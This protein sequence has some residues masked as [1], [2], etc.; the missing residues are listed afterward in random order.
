MQAHWIRHAGG[1][2]GAGGE[3]VV[4]AFNRPPAGLQIKCS[5]PRWHQNIAGREKRYAKASLEGFLRIEKKDV[6][7]FTT[8]DLT[9]FVVCLCSLSQGKTIHFADRLCGGTEH[10]ALNMKYWTPRGKLIRRAVIVTVRSCHRKW[11]QSGPRTCLELRKFRNDITGVRSVVNRQSSDGA[12]SFEI[13]RTSTSVARRITSDLW[14][15]NKK[16]S[17]PYRRFV[18]IGLILRRV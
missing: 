15:R 9:C 14:K 10:Q 4:Y 17:G 13:L 5:D 6:R 12:L 11:R 2:G 8:L 7:G 18:E 1:A 16:V 3:G